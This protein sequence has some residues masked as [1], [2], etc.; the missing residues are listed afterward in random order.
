MARQPTSNP[1]VD[2][3]L[4]LLE[5]LGN[6]FEDQEWVEKQQLRL[7]RGYDRKKNDG[8]LEALLTRLRQANAVA[9]N[10]TSVI[11]EPWDEITAKHW[12]AI[13]AGLMTVKQAYDMEDPNA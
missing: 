11:D 6:I 10:D 1:L 12:P 8:E 3:A 5:K 4:S 9:T 13:K 7:I 2:E